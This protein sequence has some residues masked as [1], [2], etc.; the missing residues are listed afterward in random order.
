MKTIDGKKDEEMYLSFPE[1]S[2]SFQPI[3]VPDERFSITLTSLYIFLTF[4]LLLNWNV[5]F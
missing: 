3:F 4:Y 5:V 1:K 2:F